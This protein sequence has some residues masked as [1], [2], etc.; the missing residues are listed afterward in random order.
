MQ[1]RIHPL[2]ETET[3]KKSGTGRTRS[4]HQKP[5]SLLSTINQQETTTDQTSEVEN[6]TLFFIGG[7]PG[8]GKSSLIS[9]NSFELPDD[10]IHIDPDQ[11]KTT[12]PD[13]D[14]SQPDLVH[15]LSRV[16]TSEYLR[17]A[18]SQQQDVAVQGTGKRTE[19]L[20]MA[21][22][23]QYKTVGHFVWVPDNEA[24]RR[25][26]ARRNNGGSNI[27]SHFGSTIAGELRDTVYPDQIKE[28]LYDEF[29]LWDN[30]S[31][32][33]RK[34]ATYKK[35]GSYKINDRSKFNRFFG[36]TAQSVEHYWRHH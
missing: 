36:D 17:D 5:N 25:I 16:R 21:K 28:G 10:T 14:I 2:T 26:V 9:A 19:H 23:K 22:A 27:P 8:A 24:D 4:K 34:I 32:T 18:I 20:K 12:L 7:T 29:H 11:I 6:P 35:G 31:N 15:N 33:P 30:S 13:W 1:T 3:E